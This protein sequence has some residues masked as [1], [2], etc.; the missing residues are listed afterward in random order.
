MPLRFNNGM[1]GQGPVSF[2]WLMFALS[3]SFVTWVVIGF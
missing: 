3:I 2:E 1:R